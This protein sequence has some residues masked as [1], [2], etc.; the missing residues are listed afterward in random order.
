MAIDDI[1]AKLGCVPD[2]VSVRE[3][4]TCGMPA[5]VLDGDV[6]RTT[7]L[8]PNVSDGANEEAISL[9]DVALGSTSVPTEPVEAVS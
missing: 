4:G 8:V 1:P 5:E 9:P 6:V 7:V 3:D 2:S